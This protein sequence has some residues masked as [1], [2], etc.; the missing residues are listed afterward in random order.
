MVSGTQESKG[1]EPD[2]KAAD[3]ASSLLLIRYSGD[4][5]TKA[6]ATRRLS[7]IHI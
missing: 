1:T 2:R 5:T 4:L 3:G 7:L 6:E